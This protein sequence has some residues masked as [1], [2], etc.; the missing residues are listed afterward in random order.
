MRLSSDAS[1][2]LA[3][4]QMDEVAGRSYRLGSTG[5]ASSTGRSFS[6]HP[7]NQVSS[8]CCAPCCVGAWPQTSSAKGLLHVHR[9]LLPSNSTDPTSIPPTCPVKRRSF[10][11]ATLACFHS[12]TLI[13]PN[14]GARLPE[15]KTR[16]AVRAF[17]G[18][19]ADQ[20]T[21]WRAHENP[22]A[23]LHNHR[24]VEGAIY[25]AFRRDW[26]RFLAHPQHW[27]CAGPDGGVHTGYL[28]DHWCD[29]GH[30]LYVV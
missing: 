20:H 30:I 21:S 28:A 29:R 14:P 11:P 23:T 5:G 8:A 6:S 9:R 3:A 22:G 15:C 26:E 13:K 25:G 27:R 16:L 2:L 4:A 1:D 10:T 12:I 7:R 17:I 24:L 19:I 18:N